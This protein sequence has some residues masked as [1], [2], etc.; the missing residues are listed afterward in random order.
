MVDVMI[1][2]NNDNSSDHLQITIKVDVDLGVE[3]E[4][5]QEIKKFHR[6]DWSNN[7]FIDKYNE[8][9]EKFIAEMVY[10]FKK[11]RDREDL[12]S[13]DNTVENI[14]RKKI[15]EDTS[16]FYELIKNKVYDYPVT[17]FE[18]KS[19]F[20]NLKKFYTLIFNHGIIP[21]DFNVSIVTPIPKSKTD[22]NQPSDFRQI[23]VSSCFAKVLEHV[24]LQNI[25]T[26]QYSKTRQ[27]GLPVGDHVF[28]ENYWDEKFKKVQKALYSLNG[29]G[30][31]AFGLEPKVL[32]RL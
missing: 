22:N 6:F 19:A 15:E 21:D 5:K 10:Y 2:N 28:K 1:C 29:V 27:F 9:L 11:E 14:E 32:A 3:D 20:N 23:S 18:V 13:A 16:S 30:C 24:I 7:S 4:F 17:E 26:N 25:D 12:F 8:N 31:R